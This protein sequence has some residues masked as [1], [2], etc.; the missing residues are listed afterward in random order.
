MEEKNQTYRK[1]RYENEADAN[2]AMSFVNATA[3]LL[4]IVIWV[5]YITKVFTIPDHFYLTVCI[6]FP[7]IALLM[8]TPLFF[9]KTEVIKKPGYKYFILFSLLIVIIALN[10]AIPKHSLLFWPFAVLMANH[11]YNPVI[12]RVI[13]IVSVVA[14]LLCLYLGMFFGEFDENLFGGGVVKPDGSVGTVETFE[15]R[16][17]LLHTLMLNGNNRYIKVMVYYFFPRASILTLFFIVSNLLNRRTYALL[18]NEIRIH[19][20]QEKA[21][22]ELG[23]AN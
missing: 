16:W 6:M 1:V 8:F 2:K 13:Y 19:E 4:A 14:M 20:E 7:I 21:Q 5:L 18:E 9:V 3:G 11:Y 10:I 23:V 17:E 22:T 12:G 15:E